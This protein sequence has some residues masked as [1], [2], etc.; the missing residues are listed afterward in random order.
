M[1]L[2]EV[3]STQIQVRENFYTTNQI[4]EKYRDMSKREHY[5]SQGGIPFQESLVFW[6][7]LTEND[8]TDHIS[9]STLSVYSPGGLSWDSNE[10]M[11]LF[12]GYAPASTY[13]TLFSWEGLDLDVTKPVTSTNMHH[14]IHSTIRFT[15]TRT[16]YTR[17]FP[18]FAYIAGINNYSYVCMF[19]AAV[20]NYTFSDNQVYKC[21]EVINGN[22]VSLYVNGI[23][24]NTQGFNGSGNMNRTQLG[25]TFNLYPL[26]QGNRDQGGLSYNKDIRVYNRPLSDSEVAQL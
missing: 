23:K 14:T 11:Y 5:I 2:L 16:I 12:D 15:N 9:G 1:I 22:T 6:A 13:K 4:I 3:S 25:T 26:H 20:Y 8:L 21:T 18:T 19:V 7:P 10:G 24:T 17:C